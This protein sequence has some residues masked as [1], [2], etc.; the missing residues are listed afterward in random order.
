MGPPE[1]FPF[2]SIARPSSRSLAGGR[3]VPT[4][5]ALTLAV[6]CDAPVASSSGSGS[7]ILGLDPRACPGPDP[8]IRQHGNRSLPES[9]RPASR[10]AR[11]RACPREGGGPG[12][13]DG[14][15]VRHCSG[16]LVWLNESV[17]T[18]LYFVIATYF[19]ALIRS[20]STPKIGARNH[21]RSIWYRRCTCGSTLRIRVDDCTKPD[22]NW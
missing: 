18:N 19:Q 15:P 6:G 4:N 11:V 12:M 3:W 10:D 16:R 5:T 1:W 13:T 2:L 7:V 9:T 21:V 17:G 22:T 8:G 14:W 20:R